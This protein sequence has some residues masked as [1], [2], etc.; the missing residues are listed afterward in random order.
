LLLPVVIVLPFLALLGWWIVGRGL[1]PLAVVAQALSRRDPTTLQPIA[2][3]K[4]PIEVQPLVE[5]LNALLQR[6]DESFD[7]QR[8]FAADA[9]HELRT[10][11]TALT[12]QI[13]LAARA[14][15]GEERTIAFER[16]EQGVKRATRMVQQLLT[17]ARLDPEAAQKPA[18][19]IDLS[20]LASAVVDELRPLAAQKSIGLDVDAESTAC[21]S[22]HDDALRILLTNLVDNAIRYTEP[23]GRVQVSVR[24]TD[25]TVQLAVQDTGPGIPPDERERVFDRF[26]RGRD[27]AAGGSGL[28]LAIVRQIASLH[29]ANVAL[30]A[31]EAGTGIQALVTFP[32]AAA[33]GRGVGPPPTLSCP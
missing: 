30:S 25:A 27:A 8:R 24:S 12:L 28:G 18:A 2:V 11:L 26:Y 9:A 19:P 1:A 16:M 21:V 4:A 13:Q 23:G 22:G 29:G 15:S 10:P 17:L 5:S 6:L 14:Q 33:V 31:T 20:A 3:D 7:T 32:A